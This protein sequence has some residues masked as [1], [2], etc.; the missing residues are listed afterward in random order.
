[1]ND[2]YF[3]SGSID[4]KVR[5]WTIRGSQVIDW[6]ETRDIVTAVSFRPDAQVC[7]TALFILQLF[8]FESMLLMIFLFAC[9]QG[10][11]I[12]CITGTCHIFNVSG[13]FY[14]NP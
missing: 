9:V 10:G 7:F 4:G 2:D 3:I 11:I 5:M 13:S 8:I 12:G 6:T 1:M 14:G